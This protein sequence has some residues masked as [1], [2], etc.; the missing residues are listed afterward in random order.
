MNKD[1]KTEFSVNVTD[2]LA[3]PNLIPLN[4]N[5]DKLI[6]G[7]L[8]TPG[9]PVQ[10]SYNFYV[11]LSPHLYQTAYYV[12]YFSILSLYAIFELIDIQFY[13]KYN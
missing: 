10:P 1:Y 12:I 8:E 2:C 5:F 3:N 9:R 4:E 7:F 11:I 13:E 6:K